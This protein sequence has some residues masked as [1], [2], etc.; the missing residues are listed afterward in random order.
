MVFGKIASLFGGAAPAADRSGDDK[1]HVWN[2]GDPSEH[3]RFAIDRSRMFDLSLTQKLTDL[4]GIAS[5][6]R[7]DR[8]FADF[9]PAAWNA[10][11]ALP[12]EPWFKGPDGF[13]YLRLNIPE[14]GKPF[15]SNSLANLALDCLN[16]GSGAVL[17]PDPAAEAPGYVFPM[18]VIDCMMRFDDWRGDPL[19]IEEAA[20]GEGKPI[21][22]LLVTSPS[23]DFL[24]PYAARALYLRMKTDWAIGDPRVQLIVQAGSA[25]SRSLVVNRR[26]GELGSHEI[27]QFFC[28]SLG[29]HLPPG[30]PITL[31]PDGW[32]EKDMTPLAELF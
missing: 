18:G 7:D 26:F 15:E 32:N 22:S 27:A 16:R 8:W 5:E 10:S 3:P 2:A 13:E 6:A 23:R 9:H 20:R 24:P 19:D 21:D 1:Y 28:A 31:L 30:R 4:L 14:P 29:W 25:P 11:I 17:F 12:A